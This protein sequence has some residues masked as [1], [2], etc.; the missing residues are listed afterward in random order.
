MWRKYAPYRNGY[1]LRLRLSVGLF[2]ALAV[3]T[4]ILFAFVSAYAR[5]AADSAYDQLLLASALSIADGVRVQDGAPWVDLPSSAFD[6]LAMARRDRIFY[7]VSG[8]AGE[9]VTGY[10]D[11]PAPRATLPAAAGGARFETISYRGLEVRV[12]MLDRILA[13]PGLT[14]PVAIVVAQTR[15][16]RTALA[17]DILVN[18][19]L[20]ITLATLAG[21]GLIWFGVRRAL[22]PLQILERIISERQA[23]DFSA[24]AVP[25]PAEVSQLVLAIN[26]LMERLK[27]NLDTMQLFLADAAHQI[28]TPLASLRAQAELA[29]EE[30]D[31]EALRRIARRIHRNAVHAGQLTNQLLNHAMVQHRGQTR[32]RD[33]VDLGALLLQVVQRAQAVSSDTAFRLEVDEAVGS[34]TLR[35][36]AI[37]LR[38]ALTNLVDNAI[39]YGGDMVELRLTVG[40]GGGLAIEVGDRGPGIPEAE[41]ERVLQRFSRGSAAEGVTGSGLGLAIV[42]SVADE[43]GAALRLLDRPGGGLLARLEFAAPSTG[44]LQQA[45]ALALLLCLLSG[46][47]GVPA[48]GALAQ[49]PVSQPPIQS[50][51]YPALAGERARLSIAGA[52]DR[53]AMEPLLEDFRHSRPDIAIEYRDLGTAELYA[54]VVAG[55]EAAQADLVISSAIDLQVKLVNDGYTRAYRSAL[56]DA[57][58]KWANWRNEAFGFTFEPAAIVYNRTLVPASDVPRTHEA[59]IGLLREKEP[60]YRRRVGTYD[61]RDSGIGYLFATQDSVL[62]SQFWQLVSVSGNAGV[63]LFCCTRDILDRVESGEL[64]IA[65]NVLGS[66]A[67]A[68]A[69]GSSSL[70][71]VLPS[72]YTLA[73]SRVAVIPREAPHPDLAGAFVDYLLSPRGQEVVAGRAGLSVPVQQQVPVQSALHPIEL[74]PAL[75]VFLDRLKRDWFLQRWSSTI[76]LP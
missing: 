71:V 60:T 19:F 45:A 12:A 9:L 24:I 39:K 33:D 14:G 51:F 23:N 53:H 29:A 47:A 11:L 48:G 76:A 32:E 67:Q 10:G 7:R 55:R 74:G 65:Y 18:T 3:L 38:E 36:D 50:T 13:M 8:P 16:E 75:L 46:I 42:R 56:T 63:R 6:I 64:L 34:P 43:H 57:L 61:I 26:R 72:D 31:P 49:E 17:D 58:P 25:P 70:G 2:A 4:A 52:T 37:T 69:D 5:R 40:P 15:E 44:R 68:L 20:P 59:L 41:K 21:A 66:Y 1:S 73:I 27:I 22:A 54:S 35:G 30:E 28:R 62:F